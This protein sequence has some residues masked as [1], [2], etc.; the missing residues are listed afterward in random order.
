MTTRIQTYLRS[1]ATLAQLQA[2]YGIV[3]RRHREH[4]NLVLL[5]YDQISSPMGDAMVRECRGI[6]LDESDGW[7][8]VARGFDKFFNAGE[9]HAAQIDWS[10][11]RVM[12]KVDGSIIALYHYAGRW[13]AATSGSPDAGGAPRSNDADMERATQALASGMWEPRHGCRMPAPATFADYFWQTLA[14]YSSRAG[15]SLHTEDTDVT[16]LFELTGPLNRVV[17]PHAEARLTVLGARHTESGT[18]ISAEHAAQ[19]LDR[20]AVPAVRSFNLST[21]DDVVASFDAMS[22]LAQEGYVVVDADFNRIKVK[23]PGYV[24]LH[25]AKDGLTQRAFVEIARSGEVPEVVAAFP[26]LKPQLDAA[27]SAL[28]ALIASVESDYVKHSGIASQKDFALAIRGSQCTAAMFAVRAGKA[29]IVADYFR[30]M[31]IDGL[32]R[33]LGYKE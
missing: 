11:A 18:E 7:R 2:D 31:N 29:A 30:T 3:H 27:R 24:S 15:T 25:H 22:P 32:M 20:G 1:G 8:V 10:T 19:M 13:H 16:F 17:V 12:E 6:V 21:I 26:E 33:L 4:P 28:A 9:G 23:H 14:F 5:K